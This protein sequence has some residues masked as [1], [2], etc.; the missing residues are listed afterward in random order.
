[1]LPD[2]TST[3]QMTIQSYVLFSIRN[4]IP[5][6]TFSDKLLQHGAT[7]AVTF[8]L[9]EMAKQAASLAMNILLHPGG[10]QQPALFAPP[11]KTKIN[12]NMAAK[13]GIPIAGGRETDE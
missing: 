7:L 3:N 4:K 6:L 8:T 1:M 10:A 9:D 5:L 11:V 2:L 12:R 13:L